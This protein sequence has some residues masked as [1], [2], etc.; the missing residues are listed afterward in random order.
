MRAHQEGLAHDRES[1]LDVRFARSMGDQRA[2]A[3]L[4]DRAEAHAGVPLVDEHERTRLDEVAVLDGDPA[5]HWHPLLAWRDG[6]PDPVGYV[7]LLLTPE[8]EAAG[9]VVLAA[10]AGGD[11][12]AIL[13]EATRT[14]AGDHQAPAVGL[15]ARHAPEWLLDTAIDLGWNVRRRLLVLG[16][17]LDESHGRHGLPD[18]VALVA[19]GPGTDEAVAKLLRGAYR[20]TPNAD[21]DAGK[22]EALRALPWSDD[23][24]L[25]LAARDGELLGVH[26]TKRRDATTGEVY[27][28]AVAAQ[29]RGLGLGSALLDL[30]LEHL[31]DVGARRVLLWVDQDNAAARALYTSRG[32]TDRWHDVSLGTSTSSAEVAV[33]R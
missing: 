6:E 13:L 30:G 18:G 9:D 5:R 12:L 24:D 27:N 2:A 19:P 33:E 11:V 31:R 10:G 23:E 15:W 29:A 4:L 3:A 20:G 14:L 8:S 28:L 26:W 1:G 17:D 25:L 16:V 32:F 22:V 21:W 7:G